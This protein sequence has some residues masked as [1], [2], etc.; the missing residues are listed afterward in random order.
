MNAQKNNALNSH[1]SDGEGGLKIVPP[2]VCGEGNFG[3]PSWS[4]T[5]NDGYRYKNTVFIIYSCDAQQQ[6]INFGMRFYIIFMHGDKPNNTNFCIF[7]DTEYEIYLT[8]KLLTALST[9]DVDIRLI[10]GVT[11]QFY[12]FMVVLN[13]SFQH[14]RN[15]VQ[16]G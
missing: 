10:C 14:I 6:V 16:L 7:R 3:K 12:I 11:D 2:G 1:G 13:I 9:N 5:D 4:N 15:T 8:G